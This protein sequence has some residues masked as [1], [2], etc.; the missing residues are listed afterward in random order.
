M[1]MNAPTLPYN[2]P[3]TR[4]PLRERVNFRILGFIAIFALLLG[5]PLY[6]YLDMALSG[7][8]KNR[9]DYYEV[10]L[11]AMSTFNF[12]QVQGRLEDVPPQWRE[13]NGKTVVMEG[14]IAPGGQQADGVGAKFDLVYSV[15]KCCFTGEPQIQHFVKVTVP[16]TADVKISRDGV[17]RVKG[18]L[19]VDVTRDADTGKING[20]YHVLASDVKSI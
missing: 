11:K 12:D 1:S 19:K 15:A 14:E 18:Q 10:D 8:L 20:V 13:L 16:A 6:T 2:T 17:I 9:G 5:F 3:A 4:I 7:G